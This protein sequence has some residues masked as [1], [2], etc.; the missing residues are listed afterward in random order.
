[1]VTGANQSTTPWT[2]LTKIKRHKKI[3]RRPKFA[4][5]DNT[6]T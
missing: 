6:T 2:K 1:M 5:F 4:K 3:Q